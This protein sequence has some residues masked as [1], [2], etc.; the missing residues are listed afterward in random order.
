MMAS[1]QA[2]LPTPE[3][4]EYLRMMYEENA[5]QARKHQEFRG[6]A[7]ALFMALIAGLLAFAVG[8]GGDHKPIWVAGLAIC[9]SSI[10]GALVAHKHYE[11]YEFH[12]RRLTGFRSA[13]ERGITKGLD[14]I[15][16]DC[17]KSHN[18]QH[19]IF[20]RL[21][22]HVLWLVVYGITFLIGIMLVLLGFR[23]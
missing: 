6:T 15:N 17:S 18:A 3:D 20:R 5:E 11:R 2:V 22:L 21:R 7:T 14:Q 10:V 12:L 4:R 23:T 8:G 16:S 1:G 9:G 13:I 19:P